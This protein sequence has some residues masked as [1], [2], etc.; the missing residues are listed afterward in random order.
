M[1]STQDQERLRR[2]REGQLASRDP[3]KKARQ[4]HGRI[5]RKQRRSVETFSLG[6]IWSEIP[7]VWKG[8]FYGLTVGVLAVAVVPLIWASPWALPCSAG[9]TLMLAILGLL[10]GRAQDTRDSLK[11]LVR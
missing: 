8:A 5:A 6:R 1:P 11:D 2:L 9:A 7:H 4:M 3:L 10:I